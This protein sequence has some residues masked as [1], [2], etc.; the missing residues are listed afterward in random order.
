M[1]NLIKRRKRKGR[2]E[3]GDNKK[4]KK[5]LLSKTGEAHNEYQ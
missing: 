4:G 3:S 1:Y 2:G 5:Q